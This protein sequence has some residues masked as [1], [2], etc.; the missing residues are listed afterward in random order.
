MDY[1]GSST[2]DYDA[3]RFL[4]AIVDSSDDAIIGKDLDG[5]V[6]T[7]NRGAERLYG[8]TADEMKGRSIALLVPEDRTRELAFILE[9]MR[10]G[11]RVDHLETLRRTK[12][13][14]LVEVSL[15][16]SPVIDAGG[17]IIGGA[18]LARD[19]SVQRRDELALV[20][21]RCVGR[22]LSSRPLMALSSS[23]LPVESRRSMPP[24][25]GCSVRGSRRH[26]S[27]RQHADAI[28]VSRE[29][30][31]RRGELPASR[32]RQDHRRWTRS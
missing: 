24:P 27:K 8:Y 26:R 32:H 25:S 31:R 21:A 6:L 22:R 5:T 29:A 18:T 1:R 3:S 15:M 20:R 14:R 2:S 17:H 9:Q 11:K 16:V 28:A 13:G 4:A 12:N 30:R 23:M 7:W 19:L 10:I